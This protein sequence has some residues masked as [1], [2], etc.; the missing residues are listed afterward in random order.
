MFRH[1]RNLLVAL[2]VTSMLAVPAF[3][4]NQ[5]NKISSEPAPAMVDVLLMRPIGL[6]MLGVSAAMFVPMA[7]VT[8]IT[9]PKEVPV[10]YEHM[11]VK[12]AQFVFSDP[13]GSH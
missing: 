8:G 5:V 12:P 10:V 13:I 1:L 9:R 4:A 11:I 2:V 3:G 7:A 6:V